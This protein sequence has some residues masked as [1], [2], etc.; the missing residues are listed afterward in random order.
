MRKS[1]AAPISKI[2]KDFLKS[3]NLN[4]KMMEARLINSWPE[5]VGRAVASRTENLLIKN[6]VLFVYMKSSVARNELMMIRQGLV[7]ALNDAA[8]EELIVDI[9]I[10]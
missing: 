2:L 10:R 1:Q 6:K 4:N 7:R 9:V 8:G 3:H 5:V